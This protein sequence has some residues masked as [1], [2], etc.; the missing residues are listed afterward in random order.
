MSRFIRC[1]VTFFLLAGWTHAIEIPKLQT[2]VTDLAGI[3]TTEE[4]AGLEAKLKDLETSDST[5]VAVLIIPSLEGESLE[6]FSVR[7]ATAWG[8]GQ[9]GRDN[10][11]LLLVALKERKVRIETGYGLEPTLTD[12]KSHTIIQ[13]EIIP[14]FRQGNYGAGVDAGITAIIQ[15]VRGAYEPTPVKSNPSSDR[16]G[17]STLNF[18]IVLLMPLLWIMSFTGKWGGGI[19]GAIAGALLPYSLFG[20]HW[21]LALFGG[22]FG[23]VIGIILGAMVRAGTRSQSHK[24]GWAGPFYWGGS[25]GGGTFGGGGFGGGGFSGGGGSFGGGGSSGSW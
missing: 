7:T 9:K 19:L 20:H 17:R 8:L 5:Q 23:G 25:G 2:R 22:I 1:L 6:D 24:G 15:V 21:I 3:L 4:A 16:S 10:G 14:Q 18:L 11:A 13:N 12:A